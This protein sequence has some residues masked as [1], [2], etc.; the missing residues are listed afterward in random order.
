M[1]LI[2]G[3]DAFDFND[4]LRERRESL[5]EREC[6]GWNTEFSNDAHVQ[7]Y[8]AEHDEQLGIL[9]CSFSVGARELRQIG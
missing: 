9:T 3:D 5:I 7:I 1:P 2:V 4:Y 8:I 6:L